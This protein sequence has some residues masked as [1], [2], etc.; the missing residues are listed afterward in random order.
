MQITQPWQVERSF[1]VSC[2][3]KIWSSSV[4]ELRSL[5]QRMAD[6]RPEKQLGEISFRYE[7]DNHENPCVVHC[8]FKGRAGVRKRFMILRRGDTCRGKRQ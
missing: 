5:V 2:P 7:L 6:E 8:Y 4:A 1:L 3:P